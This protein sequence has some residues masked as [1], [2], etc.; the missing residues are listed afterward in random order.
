MASNLVRDLD[1]YFDDDG[2]IV[3]TEY[4]H[5]NRG[6]C[7]GNACRHCPFDYANV[8]PEARARILSLKNAGK[9]DAA[10]ATSA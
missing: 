3:L 4:Y 10:K 6:F 2:S 8:P 5:L 7:C 1:Y 9:K